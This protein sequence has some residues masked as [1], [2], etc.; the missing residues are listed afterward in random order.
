M[1]ERYATPS[2][3]GKQEIRSSSVIKMRG[4]C[5]PQEASDFYWIDAP[6]SRPSARCIELGTQS[7]LDIVNAPIMACGNFPNQR[8]VPSTKICIFDEKK[9]KW[10]R[11]RCTACV[12][13]EIR[14]GFCSAPQH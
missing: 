13:H 11:S 4:I 9:N 7:A 3:Q 12:P 10:L 8:T 1:V 6:L 14:L 5:T 2:D